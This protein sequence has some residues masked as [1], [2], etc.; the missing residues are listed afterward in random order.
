MPCPLGH[1]GW[2]SHNR[3]WGHNFEPVHHFR[4]LKLYW[5]FHEIIFNKTLHLLIPQLKMKWTF[6]EYPDYSY[7][8]GVIWR[9]TSMFGSKITTLYS[10]TLSS[11][12]T[13]KNPPTTRFEPAIPGLGGRWRV[14]WDASGGDVTTDDEDLILSLCLIFELWNYTENFMKLFLIKHYIYWSLK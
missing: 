12:M 1:G 13:K 4:T 11:I 2:G 10:F 9:Q 14:S 3:R 8:P 5:E 6:A 7:F